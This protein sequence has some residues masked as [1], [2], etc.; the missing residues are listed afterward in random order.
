MK[1]GLTVYAFFDGASVAN[2]VN[3]AQPVHTPL[4]GINT[5]TAHPGGAGALTTDA[6][7]AVSGTFLI[8]NNASLTLQLVQKNL[9]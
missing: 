8:P 2:F 9:D 6:N 3:E 7:G 1:P 4:V 5:V